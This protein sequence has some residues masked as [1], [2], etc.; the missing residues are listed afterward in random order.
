MPFE[1][2]V[3]LPERIPPV[4]IEKALAE[5]ALMKT[6]TVAIAAIDSFSKVD[7]LFSPSYYYK[8]NY[9]ENTKL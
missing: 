2:G 1:P 6:E 4:V 8:Y 7:I 5:L 3:G 9:I